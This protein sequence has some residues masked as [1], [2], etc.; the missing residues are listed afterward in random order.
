MRRSH[1]LILASTATG[2]TRA[3][4]ADGQVKLQTLT[5]AQEVCIS[6]GDLCELNAALEHETMT[7]GVLEELARLER[8]LPL[9]LTQE[10]C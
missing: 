6:L 8:A 2:C 7:D 9:P 4:I 3:V 5:V 1:G 10:G